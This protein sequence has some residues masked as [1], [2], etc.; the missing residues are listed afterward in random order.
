[1]GIRGIYTGV[2]LECERLV[3]PQQS[4]LATWP[5]DLIESRANCLANLGLL[6]CNAT[7][8]VTL[9]LPCMLHT[10]ASFG[11]L[12]AA[13]F[14]HEALLECT[15]LCISSHSLIHYPYMIPT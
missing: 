4:G 15:L 8:G 6:S 12:P 1:M 9:Q 7:V 5:R 14:S 3:F 13:R 11:D 10:C 2:C